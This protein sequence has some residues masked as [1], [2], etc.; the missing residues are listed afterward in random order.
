MRKNI[1]LLLL[2][3][4]MLFA[5]GNTTNKT[6]N[7]VANEQDSVQNFVKETKAVSESEG[8][9]IKITAAEFKELIYNYEANPQAWVFRGDK[10]CVIDFYADWCRPCKMIAPILDELAAEYAGKVNFYKVDT[11]VEQEL[12]RVFNI[13]SIPLVVFC[14]VQGNPQGTM[15]AYPKEEYKRL[16]ESIISK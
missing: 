3:P 6:G 8:K 4:T 13:S 5:C 2:I 1:A 12:A 10:P 9:V 16:I 14:G 7:T 11:Q 15:G